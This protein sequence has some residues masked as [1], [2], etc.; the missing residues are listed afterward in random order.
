MKLALFITLYL[1][2]GF[3]LHVQCGQSTRHFRARP[4]HET[5][6]REPVS[7]A[8]GR[9]NSVALQTPI[10][11]RLCLQVW[12]VYYSVVRRFW[13]C[14]GHL[15]A[16]VTWFFMA[17]CTTGSDWWKLS[18]RRLCVGFL[19]SMGVVAGRKRIERGNERGRAATVAREETLDRRCPQLGTQD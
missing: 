19:S 4:G 17:T 3:T 1:M 9:E 6:K 2:K 14:G 18:L 8:G 11:T 13:G 16:L 10:M 15:G 7:C 12:N 5:N